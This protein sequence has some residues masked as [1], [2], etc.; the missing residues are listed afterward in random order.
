MHI[1][2]KALAWVLA[3][4]LLSAEAAALAASPPDLETLAERLV[5]LRSE[6]E[7]LQVEIE[8]TR[9]SHRNRMATLSQRRASLESQVQAKALQ[10]RQIRRTLEEQ[11]A[12]TRAQNEAAEAMTPAVRSV[13]AMLTAYIDASI[14]FK[15]EDRRDRKSVV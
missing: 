3:G 15:L 11:R 14:P 12:K 7:E 10:L 8:S 6:V 5:E 9:Q 1:L 13:A 2:Q 4:A